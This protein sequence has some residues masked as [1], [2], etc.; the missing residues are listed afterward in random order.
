[1]VGSLA[2]YPH[3]PFIARHSQRDRWIAMKR[4]ASGIKKPAAKMK[5][6]SSRTAGCFVEGWQDVEV[7]GARKTPLRDRS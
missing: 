5:K 3:S 6:P 2:R 1:M 7:T 4:P